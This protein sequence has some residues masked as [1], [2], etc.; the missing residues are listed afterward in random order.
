MVAGL[1][2]C[3]FSPG[4]AVTFAIDNTQSSARESIKNNGNGQNWTEPNPGR[5]RQIRPDLTPK[6]ALLR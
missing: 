1:V 3:F 2:G 4:G 5:P 6:L